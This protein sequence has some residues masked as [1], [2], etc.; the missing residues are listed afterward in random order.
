MLPCM[1]II[2]G[3]RATRPLK[4]DVSCFFVAHMNKHETMQ[5][6]NANI[7]YLHATST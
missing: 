5:I 6:K 4:I 1:K 3:K 2:T 7:S